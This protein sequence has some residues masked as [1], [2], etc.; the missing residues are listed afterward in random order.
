ME[1]IPQKW[2][3]IILEVMKKEIQLIKYEITPNGK[4]HKTEMWDEYCAYS[5]VYSKSEINSMD[6]ILEWWKESKE[7]EERNKIHIKCMVEMFNN[8]ENGK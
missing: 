6:Y 1:I 3:Y 7:R 4:F 8:R 5:C 2:N